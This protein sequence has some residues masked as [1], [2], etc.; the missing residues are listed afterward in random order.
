MDNSPITLGRE[1]QRRLYVLNERAAGRLTIVEAAIGLNVSIRHLKRLKA[2]YQ[3]E[4]IAALVHGNRGRHPR[5]AVSDDLA[6]R[7]KELARTRYVG[8]NHSHLADLLA[9]REGIS[10][11]RSTI[12]R[13]LLRAGLRSPR[14]R[15]PPAHRSRRERMAREGACSRPTAVVTAGSGRTSR[16]PC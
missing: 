2:R 15:R 11:E 14:P 4:G 10:L 12:R 5:N 7:V 6:G 13:M 16:S 3:G 9:E 1:G 8:L